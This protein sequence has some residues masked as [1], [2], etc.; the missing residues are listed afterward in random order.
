MCAVK[1]HR[2]WPTGDW[3]RTE[4]KQAAI[5]DGAE[6]TVIDSMLMRRVLKATV[7]AVWLTTAT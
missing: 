2:E 5:A 6:F 1:G 4:M 7:F 3:M